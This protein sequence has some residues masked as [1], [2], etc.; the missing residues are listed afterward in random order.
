M[1]QQAKAHYDKKQAE[2]KSLLKSIQD[3]IKQHEHA[4]KQNGCHWG[5][6]GDLT[7]IA[8]E[9]QELSDRLHRVGEYA[10]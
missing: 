7:S 8:E 1:N 3:G 6:V 5:Y 2:I 9:L 4:S 10:E